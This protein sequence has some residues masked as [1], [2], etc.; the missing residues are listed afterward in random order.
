M[1]TIKSAAPAV[2]AARGMFSA[3]AKLKAA[4]GAVAK[5]IAARNAAK[6]AYDG[7][8]PEQVKAALAAHMREVI[9]PTWA[10]EYRLGRK[11]VLKKQNENRKNKGQELVSAPS[12]RSVI[13]NSMKNAGWSEEQQKAF[14]DI[15]SDVLSE[16]PSGSHAYLWDSFVQFSVDIE[17]KNRDAVTGKKLGETKTDTDTDTETE[18]KTKTAKGR[19]EVKTYNLT[20]PA[21]AD[22]A[23]LLQMKANRM[24]DDEKRK[25]ASAHLLAFCELAGITAPVEE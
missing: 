9:S 15:R 13:P 2:L 23:T 11:A 6:T 22:A 10:N 8:N 3:E 7:L 12:G 24:D 20:K 21:L 14:T 5:A 1:T 18:T 17:K 25:A 19:D 4:R 16:S